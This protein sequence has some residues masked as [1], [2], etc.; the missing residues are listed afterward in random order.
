MPSNEERP[1]GRL[2]RFLKNPIVNVVVGVAVVV[3][4]TVEIVDEVEGAS[5]IKAAHGMIL[6]G[7]VHA[8]RS[9]AELGEGA[10]RLVEPR[11]TEG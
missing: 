5:D 8:L 11:E 6:L 9:F 4:S 3:C 7:L 2:H 1:R 10:H